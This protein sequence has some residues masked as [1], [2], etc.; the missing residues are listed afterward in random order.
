MVPKVKYVEPGLRAEELDYI[1][2]LGHYL[3]KVTINRGAMEMANSV[4][5]M[6]QWLAERKA[7]YHMD[8]YALRAFFMFLDP[9]IALEFKVRF[10]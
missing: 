4:D 3:H 10:A 8:V 1:Y 2:A 9:D 6:E 7:V 5:E